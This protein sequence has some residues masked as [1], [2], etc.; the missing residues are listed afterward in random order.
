M[1]QRCKPAASFHSTRAMR[2]S[3]ASL[4]S[5][6]LTTLLCCERP[7]HTLARPGYFPT[8]ECRRP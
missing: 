2:L 5:H 7:I 4:L 6:A 3:A 8:R 1:M